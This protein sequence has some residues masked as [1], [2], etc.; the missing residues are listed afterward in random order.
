LFRVYVVTPVAVVRYSQQSKPWGGKWLILQKAVSR[1]FAE[2]QKHSETRLQKP[3]AVLTCD[4]TAVAV[5]QHGTVI[6]D[7][8]FLSPHAI[9]A[10]IVVCRYYYKHI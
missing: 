2:V 8:D 4:D 9:T 6:R 5:I 7:A 3:F 10:R 1:A